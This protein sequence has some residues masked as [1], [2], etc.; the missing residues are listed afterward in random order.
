MGHSINNEIFLRPEEALFL[1]ERGAMIVE[2]SGVEMSIQ[3]GY[4]TFIG[5]AKEAEEGW[6]TLEQYQVGVERGS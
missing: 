5:N 1:L 2:C 3:Q 4:A 6:L